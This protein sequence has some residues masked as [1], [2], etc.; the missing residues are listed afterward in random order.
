M[1]RGCVTRELGESYK[2][3]LGNSASHAEVQTDRVVMTR[4]A[5]Q[6]VKNVSQ[7]A[8]ASTS[9]AAV[10]NSGIAGLPCLLPAATLSPIEE[11]HL[12]S[13]T[14]PGRRL[15]HAGPSRHAVVVFMVGRLPYTT[16]CAKSER[17]VGLQ[18]GHGLRAQT[19]PLAQHV[20]RVRRRLRSDHRRVERHRAALARAAEWLRAVRSQPGKME[21]FPDVRLE[22]DGDLRGGASLPTV[23]AT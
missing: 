9:F 15:R 11:E 22:A 12:D 20:L 2:I 7:F 23:G 14:Q 4:S 10:H 17:A 21:K 1:S 16:P 8:T 3:G 5:N 13:T 19:E 18:R 6:S